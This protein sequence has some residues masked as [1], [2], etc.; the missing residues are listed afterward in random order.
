MTL[1]RLWAEYRTLKDY[2][3]ARLLWRYFRGTRPKQLGTFVRYIGDKNADRMSVSILRRMRWLAEDVG[4]LTL[5][6]H[7]EVR[8]PPTNDPN[9]P[10]SF[11][12]SVGWKA[13]VLQ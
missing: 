10:L 13:D 2:L 3:R 9:D 4:H 1:R 7:Q 11:I 12:G 5:I 8:H 6:N